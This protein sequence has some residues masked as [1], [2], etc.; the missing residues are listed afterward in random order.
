L[1]KTLKVKIRALKALADMIQHVFLDKVQGDVLFLER[2]QAI[3]LFEVATRNK[4]VTIRVDSIGRLGRN[5][6]DIL[7]TIE[8]LTAN[9]VNLKAIK[10][11]FESLIIGQG[12][13]K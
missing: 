10:E 8:L 1:D 11:G 9:E 5:L 2:P 6:I 13:V 12:T 4:G 7:N 3:K